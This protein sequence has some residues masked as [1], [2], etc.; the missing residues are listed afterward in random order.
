MK[1]ADGKSGNCE[2]RIQPKGQ[3]STTDSNDMRTLTRDQVRSLDQQAIEEFHIPG[4]VL[5]ENAARGATDVLRSLGVT[6][7]VT[8]LC[9]KG[10][11]AGDGLVVARHLDHDGLPVQVISAGDPAAW[12]GDTAVNYAIAKASGIAIERFTDESR[13]EELLSGTEWIVDGLLGTGATGNPRAPFDIL[14]RCANQSSA[15]RF[16]LDLPSGL[17]CDTGAAGQPTFL[18]QHTATFV[19]AKPG[20]VTEVA[21]PYVGQLHVVGIGAPRV[22]LERVFGF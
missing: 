6:D 2:L 16:A 1:I 8:I 14:I 13:L 11:N 20:L 22:L 9:G 18:A 17:E 10:N 4:I 7:K 12:Q 3:P 19:A 5:M 21:K 15:R